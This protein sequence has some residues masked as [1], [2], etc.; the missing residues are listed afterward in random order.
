MYLVDGARVTTVKSEVSLTKYTKPAKSYDTNDLV[1][2]FIDS[3][4]LGLVH[5]SEIEQAAKR[6]DSYDVFMRNRQCFIFTEI[7]RIIPSKTSTV[8]V[9]ASMLPYRLHNPPIRS[10]FVTS[11]LKQAIPYM[12]QPEKRIF[13]NTKVL[14]QGF[15]PKGG[16]IAL[17]HTLKVAVSTWNGYN[18]EDA[19]VISK[20]VARKFRNK[21]YTVVTETG[22]TVLDVYVT[23]GMAVKVGTPLFRTLE[24]LEVKTVNISKSPKKGVVEK[25]VVKEMFI[26]IIMSLTKD[27]EVGDKMSSRHGQ[28]GVV[29][30][31]EKDNEML[32]FYDDDGNTVYCD[33]I[34]SPFAFPSRMTM[35]Q[36]K[37]MEE[38]G[39]E[40][41]C[42][43]I[44]NK[45]FVGDCYYMALK[46]QVEDKLQYREDKNTRVNFITF[47]PVGG[48][49]FLGGLRIGQM[50]R[51]VLIACNAW[52]TLREI[53]EID[54]TYVYLDSEGKVY[55]TKPKLLLASF[56]HTSS[57]SFKIC[58]AY[59][60]AIG[61]DI[62][63]DP[64]AKKYSIVK[65]DS[66]TLSKTDS[67]AFGYSDVL[68]LRIYK[69]VV[70]LPYCLRSSTLANLYIKYIGKPEKIYKETSHL[71]RSKDGCYHALVE[72]HK[73]RMC[74][75][76]VITPDPRLDPSTVYIPGH[77]NIGTEYGILNRQPSLDVSSLALVK[78]EKELDSDIKSIRISPLLCKGFN[79]DFDGDEMNIYG[80]KNPSSIEELKSVLVA[81]EAPTQDYILASFLK[82]NNICE[83]TQYGV[84]AN[85]KCIKDMIDSNS[86]GKDF[87][88]EYMYNRIDTLGSSTNSTSNYYG[89]VTEDEWYCLSKIARLNAA[90]IGINTP[91][92]GYLESLCNSRYI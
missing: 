69:D 32:A 5:R 14:V 67:L 33:L 52:N 28:K 88:Y 49:R 66:T 87:N 71:L 15:P 20:S 13:S 79:A 31:I 23:E 36:I 45:I 39:K 21:T 74:I 64:A 6:C 55:S 30:K 56:R 38:T 92:T 3:V 22:K 47:Q 81:K 12:C 34:I 9:A 46:P 7:G 24:P 26:K 70:V 11:M 76:S 59:M 80:I 41:A 25:V 54:K 16:T 29:S 77:I 90:S 84:T 86:R 2:V 37:E 75:R 57:Q 8:S 65:F 35:G 68:D 72:G 18:I 63:I 91:I 83:L 27:I 60:R 19:I 51:D 1:H 53:Y 4:Y 44:K 61:Y 58:L 50:E 40:Y 48:K 62:L 42:K 73:S 43:N 89:G 78:L 17:G 82:L 10:M 85:K